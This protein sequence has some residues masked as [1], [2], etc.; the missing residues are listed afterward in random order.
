MHFLDT[1]LVNTPEISQTHG[2]VI[3]AVYREAAALT[4]FKHLQF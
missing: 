3:P 4:R 1:F 2:S